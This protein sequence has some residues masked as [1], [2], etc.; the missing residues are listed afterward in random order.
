[1]RV[2]YKNICENTLYG[3]VVAT[4]ISDYVCGAKKWVGWRRKRKFALKIPSCS[5]GEVDSPQILSG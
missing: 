3:T 2:G 4:D 1:M 5:V